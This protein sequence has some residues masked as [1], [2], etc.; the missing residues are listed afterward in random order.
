MNTKLALLIG[1]LFVMA[2]CKNDNFFGDTGIFSLNKKNRASYDNY[3]QSKDVN[4]PVSKDN[5]DPMIVTGGES[6]EDEAE[7]EP[8]D[9]NVQS[10]NGGSTDNSSSGSGSMTSNGGTGNM[11]DLILSGLRME[12]PIELPSHVNTYLKISLG[13]GSSVTTQWPGYNKTVRIKNICPPNG[14]AIF[15]VQI[16][17]PEGKTY[18]PTKYKNSGGCVGSYGKYCVIG[19]RDFSGKTLMLGYEME[20]GDAFHE[21]DGA[22]LQAS[23]ESP[24]TTLDIANLCYDKNLDN[25]ELRRSWHEDDLTGKV[26][27]RRQYPVQCK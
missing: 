5:D 25:N 3:I 24:S 22:V 4:N 20:G 16:L 11:G 18:V 27:R 2:S 1:L 9:G 6:V 8:G 10:G 23:C 15:N 26:Y 13:N 14:N 12:G 19:W 7:G 17:T 21:I